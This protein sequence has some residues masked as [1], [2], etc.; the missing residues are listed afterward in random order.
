MPT[1]PAVVVHSLS[2]LKASQ[3]WLAHIPC[4]TCFQRSLSKGAARLPNAMVA[5]MA[6]SHVEKIS[7]PNR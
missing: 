2:K 5:A 6:K 7:N 3:H 4:Q 1:L